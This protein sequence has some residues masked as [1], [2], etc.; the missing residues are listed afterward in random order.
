VNDQCPLR[1]V[2]N[3]CA[4]FDRVSPN[5][6]KHSAEN[7]HQ[8]ALGDLH[9]EFCTVVETNDLVGLLGLDEA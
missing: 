6:V 8:F 3:S 2:A 1:I 4:T 9:R 7:D 5:G